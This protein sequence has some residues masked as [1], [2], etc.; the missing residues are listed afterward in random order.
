[1]LFYLKKILQALFLPHPLILILMAVSLILVLRRR[2]RAWILLAVSILFFYLLSIGPVSDGLARGLENRYPSPGQ[3]PEGLT[4]V[5]V[6]GG[7]T[8]NLG[9]DLPPESRLGRSALSRAL[10]GVRWLRRLEDGRLILSGGGWRGEKMEE[11][12]S[13]LMKNLAMDM[14]VEENRIVISPG[15]RDTREETQALKELLGKGPFLLVTSGF[16]MPR[17]VRLFRRLGMDP[18]PAPSDLRGQRRAG[19]D[20]FDWMPQPQSFFNSSLVCKEYLG[21]FLDRLF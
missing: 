14:G 18:V 17:A 15:S 13:L 11:T 2:K 7:G 3:I 9:A 21:L 10:T 19:Y 1:M 5:V 4:N 12:S 16:H 6:L 20:F 8:L